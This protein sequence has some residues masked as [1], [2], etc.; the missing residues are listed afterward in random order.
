MNFS[1]PERLSHPDRERNFL[2]TMN[3][4]RWEHE[5]PQRPVAHPALPLRHGSPS[6]LPTPAPAEQLGTVTRFPTDANQGALT[7]VTA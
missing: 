7:S 4:W 5:V 2:V 3:W 6:Q 1:N